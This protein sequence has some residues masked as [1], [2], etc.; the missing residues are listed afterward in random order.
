MYASENLGTFFCSI[1]DKQISGRSSVYGFQSYGVDL[2]MW[3]ARHIKLL[4]VQYDANINIAKQ[5]T[6]LPLRVSCQDVLLFHNKFCEMQCGVTNRHTFC[7]GKFSQQCKQ[8]SIEIWLS[9][10][11]SGL[12]SLAGEWGWYLGDWANEEYLSNSDGLL[13]EGLATGSSTGGNEK[14]THRFWRISQCKIEE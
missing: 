6:L 8:L 2:S 7:L 14:E 9:P 11:V 1:I 13:S 5:F 4:K 12:S 10:L 3:L